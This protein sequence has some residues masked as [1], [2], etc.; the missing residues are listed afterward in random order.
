[1]IFVFQ[2]TFCAQVVWKRDDPQLLFMRLLYFTHDLCLSPRLHNI[3]CFVLPYASLELQY[4]STCQV[5]K[6][7][8]LFLCI[9]IHNSWSSTYKSLCL[10]YAAAHFVFGPNSCNGCHIRAWPAMPHLI[11]YNETLFLLVGIGYCV[12]YLI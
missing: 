4:I 2:S 5:Q 11:Y 3:I 6:H 8:N 7:T 12:W 10:V 9:H 1:M